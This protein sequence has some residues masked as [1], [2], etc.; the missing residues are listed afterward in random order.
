MVGETQ[1]LSSQSSQ[2]T[3]NILSGPE[4][5]TDTMSS[6]SSQST[7]PEKEISIWLDEKE[8]QHA[9]R[10]TL[11]D[12]VSTLTDGR[13]SPLLSTLNT[14]W[15]DISSTQQKY[16]TR[17]ASP[18]QEEA[19]WESLRREP[20]LENEGTVAKKRKYF[21]V[22]SD[23]IDALIEAHHQAQSWQ[24]KR[25]ILSLFAND[26]SRLELQKMIPD[27]S[28]WRI[29]QARNHAT[30]TG[31]DQPILEKPIYRA[32]IENAKVDHFLDYISRPELLQD[33][34][35]GT[36]TLKLDSGERVIIPAVVRTL[37]HS[38]IIQQYICYC[39]QEQFQPASDRSLYRILDVCSASMQKSLQGLDN[40]TA[41]GT[42]AIDHLTKMIETLVENGAEEGWGKTTDCKVKEVKRYFKTDF[43][44]HMSQEEHCADHCTT[45]SLSDPK[46]TEFKA[47]ASI[48]T[49]SNA[50]DANL[51]KKF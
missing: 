40:V 9:K 27:L 28:K 51:S 16:Y 33:V 30:E 13:V 5:E 41:E 14:E 50:N 34:A 49:M 26:F 46:N 6:Q 38:G 18:G 8:E 15:D 24:T 43:K 29:D 4:G 48:N 39:K 25:Q 31:K 45:Y 36:K 47:N 22:K 7:L 20:M 44:A 2:L 32:R 12:T 10:Q 3:D 21:D 19:L 1:S 35:F 17:K 37:I 23:L 11:N 42:E